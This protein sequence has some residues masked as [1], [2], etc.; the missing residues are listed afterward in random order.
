M[1]GHSVVQTLSVRGGVPVHRA[2]GALRRRERF[3][4]RSVM[5]SFLPDQMLYVIRIHAIFIVR[6]RPEVI[7][8]KAPNCVL[9]LLLAL[10]DLT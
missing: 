9:L 10:L 7:F 8:Q 6:R 1:T 4:L 3:L 2:D 5:I